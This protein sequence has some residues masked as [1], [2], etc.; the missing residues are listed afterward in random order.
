M[1]P[2]K[3]DVGPAKKNALLCSDEDRNAIAY[4]FL[5]HMAQSDKLVWWSEKNEIYIVKSTYL[6]CKG[7]ILDTSHLQ[8]EGNLRDLWC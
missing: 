1:C 5:P 7:C 4:T 3:G 2:G 6:M 8:V